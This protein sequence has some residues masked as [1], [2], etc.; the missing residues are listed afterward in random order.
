[1]DQMYFFYRTFSF[2]RNEEK[3]FE[4]PKSF[5]NHD[6]S[7]RYL[8]RKLI[9]QELI[10]VLHRLFYCNRKTT[11]QIKSIHVLNARNHCKK[12]TKRMRN[13]F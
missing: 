2:N 11:L 13:Q 12:I 1:M 3:K 9:K 4:V 7:E 6:L 10:L 8:F 5:I